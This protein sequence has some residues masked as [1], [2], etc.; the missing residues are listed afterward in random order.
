MYIKS[1]THDK[2]ESVCV[3]V[4][5]CAHMYISLQSPGRGTMKTPIPC[6]NNLSMTYAALGNEAATFMLSSAIIHPGYQGP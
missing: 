2:E 3:R 5:V 6:L 4:Y 1:L